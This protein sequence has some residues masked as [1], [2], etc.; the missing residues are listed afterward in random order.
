MKDEIFGPILPIIT[1][2]SAIND[3]IDLINK[4]PSPLTSYI[5]TKDS[6]KVNRLINETQSGSVLV[7]D[8]IM[9]YG[10]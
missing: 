7:N 6:K 1:V 10:E 3:G 9:H 4:G 5:F 2:N 8:V